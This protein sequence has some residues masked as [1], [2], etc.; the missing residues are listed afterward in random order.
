MRGKLLIFVL[1]ILAV[2]TIGAEERSGKYEDLARH[3]YSA[4]PQLV[5]AMAEAE[6]YEEFASAGK[7]L[8]ATGPEFRKQP[9]FTA[10][11]AEFR[12]TAERGGLTAQLNLAQLYLNGIGVSQD[13]AEAQ[14]YLRLAAAQRHSG[15]LNNLG[16]VYANGHGVPQDFAEAVKWYRLAAEQGNADA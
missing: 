6:N 7:A 4:I 5:R 11:L 12:K 10:A 16:T 13:D 3:G 1:S 2:S 14:K 9:E 8:E 15:A